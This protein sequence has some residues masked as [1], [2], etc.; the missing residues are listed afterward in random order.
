MGKNHRAKKTPEQYQKAADL[1][2]QGVPIRQ[3]LTEAGWSQKTA[4]LGIKGIPAGVLK[5][6]PAKQRELI[7]LGKSTT[8]E[9][10]KYAVLGRAMENV[11]QGKDG[12]VQSA[13]LLGNWK[14]LSMW[15]PDTQLGVIVLS[16]PQWVIDNKAKL[17]ADPEEDEVILRPPNTAETNNAKL[18]VEEEKGSRHAG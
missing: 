11:T 17:L 4:N 10:M 2:G 18:L 1:L 13:K 8:P 9:D 3:A 5:L 14:E 15:N 7:A 6:M 16:A 12:G